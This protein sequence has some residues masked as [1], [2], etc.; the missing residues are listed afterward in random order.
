[1]ALKPAAPDAL[2]FVEAQAA[3][4]RHARHGVG[5][6]SLSAQRAPTRDACDDG[7]RKVEAIAAGA[8]AAASEAT[9][10]ALA[11]DTP[12][13]W[14][15]ARAAEAAARDA[16]RIVDERNHAYTFHADPS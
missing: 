16:R 4:A 1:M 12:A 6:L 11:L 2:V 3:H 14:K 13:A 8:E 9:R 10:M 15:A 7:W 5:Q